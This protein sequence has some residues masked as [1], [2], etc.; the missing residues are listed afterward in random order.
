MIAVRVCGSAN[1]TDH[2]S[3]LFAI[4]RRLGESALKVAV[5][6]AE[7]SPMLAH[8][9]VAH[10]FQ[11]NQLMA[12]RIPCRAVILDAQV[13]ENKLAYSAEG[14]NGSCHAAAPAAL[15][16]ATS[17]RRFAVLPTVVQEVLE[18]VIGFQPANISFFQQGILRSAAL[19]TGKP[20]FVSVRQSRHVRS[21][22]IL[23][24]RVQTWQ[25]LW[26]SR[27]ITAVATLDVLTKSL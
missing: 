7:P 15:H 16:R 13:A 9:S 22:A 14:I 8:R 27:V 2:F 26:R 6:R 4:Y 21:E 12:R 23:A 18:A 11:S 24:V 3:T 17:R 1:E 25:R 20:S 10:L 19:W 5:L